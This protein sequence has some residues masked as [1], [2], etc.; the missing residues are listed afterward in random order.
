ME[1]SLKSYNENQ[2]I[3]ESWDSIQAQV[4][5]IDKNH[6]EIAFY[7]SMTYVIA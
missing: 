3:K 5:E 6:I 4:Y 1:E 2:E 7:I